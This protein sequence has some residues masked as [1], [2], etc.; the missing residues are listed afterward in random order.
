MVQQS[1]TPAAG[2]YFTG[3]CG[4]DYLAGAR[5]WATGYTR[6]DR[7]LAVFHATATKRSRRSTKTVNSKLEPPSGRVNDDSA[8]N[9]DATGRTRSGRRALVAIL[10]T[11]MIVAFA[12]GA[13]LAI[14]ALWSSLAGEPQEEP[15]PFWRS[16]AYGGGTLTSAFALTRSGMVSIPRN[17]RQNSLVENIGFSYKMILMLIVFI[18]GLLRRLLLGS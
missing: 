7:D 15:I 17:L 14:G 10:G 8:T 18:G 9:L 12:V 4:A 6:P 5:I 16:L 3:W 2:E 11:T 1:L 13:W